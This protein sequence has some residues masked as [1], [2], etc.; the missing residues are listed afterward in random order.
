VGTTNGCTGSAEV[1][2]VVN[3]KPS[4]SLASDKSS[5]C[6]GSKVVLTATNIA[7]ATYN[8]GSASSSTGNSIEVYPS[9]NST[10]GVKATVNGCTSDEV[11][12]SISVTECLQNFTYTQGFYGNIGGKTC[13]G[14]STAYLLN[15]AL[16]NGSMMFGKS[17]RTFTLLASDLTTNIYKL[18]PGGGTPASLKV[19]QWNSTL[20]GGNSPIDSKG[21][22]NN[23]LLSQTITLWFNIR[24]SD[25]L[26]G[27][28]MPNTFTTAK[29]NC[30]DQSVNFNDQKTFSVPSA[31][32]GKSVDQLFE[33]A[34]KALGAALVNGDPSLNDIYS[35][36]DLI[37][38]AFDQ[39]R[40]VISSTRNNN[41]SV[42]KTNNINTMSI[43]AAIPRPQVDVINAYPN[44]FTDKL[45]IVITAKASGHASLAI[46][47]ASGLKVADM[48][49]GELSLGEERTF[50]FFAPSGRGVQTY[51]YHFVQGDQVLQG[52]LLSL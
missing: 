38:N 43:S 23:N 11:S 25:N 9:V 19:G 28:V 36:I 50:E 51:I 18:L 47:D 12:V 15:I 8:W 5:I 44:P 48:F 34:N 1:L 6:A 29:V 45:S 26:G 17:N 27:F 3:P 46:Y 16:P 21:K 2:V 52:K 4:I 35:T 49:D 7:G 37:N 33:L 13:E 20:K 14:Y 41:T 24:T 32:A 42:I 40:A 39:G 30:G 10:Y 22:I 31:L